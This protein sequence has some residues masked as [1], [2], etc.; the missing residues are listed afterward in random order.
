MSRTVTINFARLLEDPRTPFDLA[1]GTGSATVT[2]V[3]GETT[4]TEGVTGTDANGNPVTG[5]VP[6]HSEHPTATKV[7][8]AT[9]P[10]AASV[11]A[12]AVIQQLFALVMQQEGLDPARG[13]H[14]FSAGYSQLV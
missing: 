6:F 9:I 2:Y 7:G 12:P 13:D 4:Y 10:I 11:N 5:Q 14:L 8:T 3:V 1:S